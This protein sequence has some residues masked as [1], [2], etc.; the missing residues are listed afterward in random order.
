ML[1]QDTLKSLEMSPKGCLIKITFLCTISSARSSFLLLCPQ[2][3]LMFCLPRRYVDKCDANKRFHV[4]SLLTCKELLFSSWEPTYPHSETYC[5]WSV[6]LDLVKRPTIAK[7][8]KP[9]VIKRV[10]LGSYLTNANWQK[11]RTN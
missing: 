9:F 6:F 3:L 8:R 11:A 4:L 2:S 5:L 7:Q 10:S 1:H